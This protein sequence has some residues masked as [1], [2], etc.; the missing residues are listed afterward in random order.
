MKKR[1]P[2]KKRS[3]FN[4]DHTYRILLKKLKSV[5]MN[6]IFP[7]NRDSTFIKPKSRF[8][9]TF[10]S[11]VNISSGFAGTL[12]F[13]KC[14]LNFFKDCSKTFDKKRTKNR[15]QINELL[16]NIQQQIIHEI[17]DAATHVICNMGSEV[18]VTSCNKDKGKKRVLDRLL[19]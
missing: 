6:L 19:L 8:G 5:Y 17:V 9:G 1:N 14:M 11:F 15:N 13:I 2:G 7:T 10:F 3:L 18:E 16:T 4:R 12:L